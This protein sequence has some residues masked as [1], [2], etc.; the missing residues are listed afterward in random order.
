MEGK[1]VFFECE[2]ITRDFGGLR[3]LSEVSF[4]V[5][6]KEIVGIM[7]PNGAGKTTLFNII[8]GRLRPT[9]GAIRLEGKSLVNL[10]P[11]MICRM[12]I[13]RTYQTVRPFLGFTALQNVVAGVL[14]GKNGEKLSKKAANW[15][16]GGDR[17]LF[18]DYGP[19]ELA[20]KLYVKGNIF[21]DKELLKK[22]PVLPASCV[23]S[24]R[25]LVKKRDLFERDGVFPAAVIDYRLS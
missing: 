20:D 7:G 13:W 9:S 15:A 4:K 3:A 18:K 25:L 19:L 5:L 23:E 2:R 16:F 24:S 21:S 8:S 22:L 12:G 6:E 1:R 17:S 14:F 11:Y 10:M